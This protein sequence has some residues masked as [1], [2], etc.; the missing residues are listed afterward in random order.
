MSK[1]IEFLKIIKE[2]ENASGNIQWNQKVASLKI[3]G[4]KW[5]NFPPVTSFY[6]KSR[7]KSDFWLWD[8]SK[9]FKVYPDDIFLCGFMRS[10]NTMMQ[11]MI[12]LI[13]NDFDFVKAKSI[14]RGKRFPYFE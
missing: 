6:A 10:G 8:K 9:D 3:K 14:I 13:V 4:E 11:E 2:C 7:D 1:H 12:W 5:K